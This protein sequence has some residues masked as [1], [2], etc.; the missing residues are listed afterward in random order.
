MNSSALSNDLRGHILA[1]QGA[2]GEIR[3]MTEHLWKE[4]D[5]GKKQ[6][7]ELTWLYDRV[8]ADTQATQ[9]LTLRVENLSRT[10]EANRSRRPKTDYYLNGFKKETLSVSVVPS[11]GPGERK[12]CLGVHCGSLACTSRLI[13]FLSLA[14]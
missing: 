1:T 7:G 4:I 8:N 10:V 2:M 11:A 5:T 12:G 9:D 6:I 14:T 3:N 13:G